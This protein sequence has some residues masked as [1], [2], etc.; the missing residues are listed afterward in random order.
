MLPRAHQIKIS[1]K[2]ALDGF[3]GNGII[4]VKKGLY[5]FQKLFI[6]YLV[7]FL[8][9]LCQSFLSHPRLL[10]KEEMLM[11]LLSPQPYSAAYAYL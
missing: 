6:S 11:V 9:C 7:S 1:E 8:K 10:W 3:G 5:A 4:H 2:E